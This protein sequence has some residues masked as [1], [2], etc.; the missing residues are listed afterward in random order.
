[1]ADSLQ[2]VLARLRTSQQTA[3]ERQVQA[4]AAVNNAVGGGIGALSRIAD[5][6]DVLRDPERRPSY[7]PGA[8]VRH[9][10]AFREALAGLANPDLSIGRG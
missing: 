2:N 9:P 10:G 3:V 5:S 6:L 1:M 7:G 8:E 4:T